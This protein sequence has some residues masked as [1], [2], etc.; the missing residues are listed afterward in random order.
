MVK[1]LN[2]NSLSL[3]K[4]YYEEDTSDLMITRGVSNQTQWSQIDN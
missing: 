2:K 3:E 1:Y 4:F